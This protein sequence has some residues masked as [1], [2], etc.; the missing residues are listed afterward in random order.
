MSFDPTPNTFMELQEAYQK[1]LLERDD[2]RRRLQ[3]ALSDN[4]YLQEQV[5][6]LTQE[7]SFARGEW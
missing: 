1:L 4:S 3:R 2:L 7:V 5:T 6:S